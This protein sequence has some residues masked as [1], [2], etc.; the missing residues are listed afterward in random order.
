MTHPGYRLAVLLASPAT[1]AVVNSIIPVNG[2][3]YAGTDEGVW[4]WNGSAWSPVGSLTGCSSLVLVNGILYAGTGE[5]VWYWNGSFW[6]PVG[7]LTGYAAY[8]SSLLLVNGIL[9]AGTEGG[10]W[11]M[12]RFHLVSGWQHGQHDKCY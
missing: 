7:S 12:E 2:I 6:S 5:G 9:Y 4:Y 10:V 3:L 8:V 1:P 11:S